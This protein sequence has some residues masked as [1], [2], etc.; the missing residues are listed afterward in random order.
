MTKE[1]YEIEK[2]LPE[3]FESS[4]VSLYILKTS[5]YV[6]V[7]NLSF[8][9]SENQIYYTFSLCGEIKRIIM[10]LHKIKK[11][12]C[13]FCFIEYFNKFEALQAVNIF[14]NS[15]LDSR[16]IRVDYDKGYKEGREF[17]RGHSG[18]QKRD[19]MYN[20]NDSGRPKDNFLLNKTNRSFVDEDSW[21]KGSHSEKNKKF[22]QKEN[23]NKLDEKNSNESN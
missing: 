15:V 2:K 17:G 21:N 18:C 10:G 11:T 23:F 16:I 19:E 13:G 4:D 6:Y 5:C 7:G 20:H 22:Y 3:Y 9:T 14:N 1:L 8:F 12:P